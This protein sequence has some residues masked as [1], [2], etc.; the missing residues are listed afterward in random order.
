VR[1]LLDADAHQARPRRLIERREGIGGETP[2]STVLRQELRGVVAR[3][4]PSPSGEIVWCR[5]K[6]V[7]GARDL[8]GGDRGARHLDHVPI[9]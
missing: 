1:G 7:G 5:R 2:W 9:E 3:S 8:V 4:G 6:E